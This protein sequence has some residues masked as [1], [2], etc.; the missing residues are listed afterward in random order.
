VPCA[1]EARALIAS[2]RWEIRADSRA[3]STLLFNRMSAAAI[4]IPIPMA[5]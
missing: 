4:T 5:Q 1:I 3:N 2:S